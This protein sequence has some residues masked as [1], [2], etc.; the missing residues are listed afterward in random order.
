MRLSRQFQF[1]KKR[2]ITTFPLLRIFSAQKA[3]AFVV[4]RSFNF[5]L[6]VGFGLIYVFVRLKKINWLGIVLMDSFTILLAY[7]HLKLPIAN[8]L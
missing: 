7:T 4:F 2:K 3:V 8:L 1:K 5:V 6:L